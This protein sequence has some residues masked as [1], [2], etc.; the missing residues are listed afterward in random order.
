MSYHTLSSNWAGD[1]L[2]EQMNKILLNLLCLYTVYTIK[3]KEIGRNISSYY[4]LSTI[5]Q[6]IL[7][8]VCHHMKFF[9]DPIPHFYSHHIQAYLPEIA[10]E[11]SWAEGTGWC[12]HNWVSSTTTLTELIPQWKSCYIGGAEGACEQPHPSQTGCPIDRT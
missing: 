11:D 9:L 6:N 12:Q 7:Q 2:V 1:G 4:C 3:S 8:Q 5:Q 10:E